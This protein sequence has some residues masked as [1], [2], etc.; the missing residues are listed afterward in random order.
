MEL[1]WL[2]DFLA[3][4]RTGNFSRAA[5]ERHVT[6]SAFSRRIQALEEW[7]GVPLFDRS[8]HPV[9]LTP[10][11]QQLLP[12]AVSSVEPLLD[13]RASMRAKAA[14]AAPT[15]SFVM[16]TPCSAGIFPALIARLN[17]EMGLLICRGSV[18][19]IDDV[20][21]RYAGGEADLALS[22][23]HPAL[24]RPPGFD[25]FEAI[26]IGDDPLVPVCAALR[27]GQSG[28]VLPPPAGQA[29][30]YLPYGRSS[31]IGRVVDDEV[32]RRVPEVRPQR[33][34]DDPLI[35]VLKELAL[36]A[37]G[38]AWLP[39]STIERN[40]ADGSL[41]RAAAGASWEIGLTVELLRRRKRLA[42]A[43]EAVWTLLSRGTASAYPPKR[44]LAGAA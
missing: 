6:Q 36:Q 24:P 17:R 35:F 37:L 34:F 44:R 16:P 40:L 8:A 27:R 29:L 31:F 7:A 43:A 30:L 9:E 21:E 20:A 25:E 13:F 38:V 4:V 18:R 28:F 14:E 22:Y 26:E 19:R 10:A 33:L 1:Y 2:Q 42:P 5:A 39:R 3:L 23:R 12:I 41:V 11:G 32:A 15:V